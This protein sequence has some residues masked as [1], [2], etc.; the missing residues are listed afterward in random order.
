LARSLDLVR[1]KAPF[2]LGDLRFS[3]E[4]G[5]ASALDSDTIAE[6]VEVGNVLVERRTGPAGKM[7][8]TRSTARSPSTRS[9]PRGVIHLE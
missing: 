4:P 3:W 2:A 9:V 8:S 6:G 7:R 5:Q 1:N